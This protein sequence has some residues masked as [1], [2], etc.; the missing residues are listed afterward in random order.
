MADET[1][2]NL[3]ARIRIFLEMIKFS[4]TVF[5]L[6]FALTGALL[7]ARGI[8][9]LSQILWIVI[10]MVG[11]RTAAMGLNRV[12]DA[13]IDGRN[14]RTATRAIPAGLLGKGTVTVFI[15]IS[16]GLMLYAA[17]RLNPLC[18]KL[19]PV[20]LFFLVLYS[21]CKRFT[22]MAHLVLGLCLGAAPVGAWIAIRG[23][24]ELPS[25]LLGLAVLFWVAG[26]DIL[27]ALQDLAFDR[28]AG[29]HSVP[30]KLGVT[31]SLWLARLLSIAMIAFLVWLFLLLQL[32]GF[33]L[34]GIILSSLLLFYE[35]WLLRKGDL[36]KL[37]MA[38]FSMNGYISIII[39]VATL[40]EMLTARGS[41]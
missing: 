41:A 28:D 27:Y 37:D 26:F 39:F 19:S 30:V 14:P 35:H 11:A 10:A 9:S 25:I 38:F 20:A 29:L 32:G 33:F 6:P 16:A 1:N 23:T 15:I 18:L 24:V 7:A 22:Y 36:E 31:G 17:A 3:L 34:A 8:P 13:E 4:H 21:Y 2:Q 40:L 5:A 12:I